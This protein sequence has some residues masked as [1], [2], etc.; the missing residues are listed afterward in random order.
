[1]KGVYDESV[2]ELLESTAEE[3]AKKNNNKR[4]APDDGGYETSRRVRDEERRAEKDGKEPDDRFEPKPY[5]HKGYGPGPFRG[6]VPGDTSMKDS[7]D[8]ASADGSLHSEK[9]RSFSDESDRRAARAERFGTDSH[10]SR[11][12]YNGRGRNSGGDRYRHSGGREA[13]RS[14]SPNHYRPPRRDRDDYHRDRG[15]GSDRRRDRSRDRGYRSRYNTDTS[16]Y[17]RSSRDDDRDGPARPR[18]E[19][20][21][22][23]GD[24]ER[25]RCTVFVQQLAQRLRTKDMD[26]FFSRVGPVKEAQ[27]V[28]D[29]VT[30]RSKGVGYVEFKN[31]ESVKKAIDLTGQQLM[32]IPVIVSLTEAEKNR[33]ARVAEGAATQTNGVPFHR[34]Y[35]GNIHFNVGEDD[36]SDVFGSF[37]ELEFTQ[38]QKDD[39][40]R[41][42][43][44]GFVQ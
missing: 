33:Q 25:D 35:V 44:Y 13:P 23:R 5:V 12:D 7:D 26:E 19:P 30:H 6:K 21:P 43:G 34:L 38:L 20:T 27:I 41:S 17:G 18:K 28:R 36:L 37:G 16:H 4:K 24:D 9:R 39:N 22:E 15:Y 11:D 42:K 29:R 31:E 8:K 3:V 32:G 2:A 40:G 14:R 10:E 1:M